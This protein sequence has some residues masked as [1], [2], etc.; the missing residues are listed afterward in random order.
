[1]KLTL[2][3]VSRVAFLARLE[4]GEAEKE[5]LTHDLNAILEHFNQLQELDTETVPPTSHSLPL[6]N[7]FRE[8][9]VAPGLMPEEALQSAPEARD[10][11]FIVPRIVES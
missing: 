1:M 5:R 7:V 4:L 11:C 2:E 6:T 3:E 8:D 10:N 9:V